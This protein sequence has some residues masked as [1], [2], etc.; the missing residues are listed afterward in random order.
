MTGRK[1]IPDGSRENAV[2]RCYRFVNTAIRPPPAPSTESKEIVNPC[3]IADL[4]LEEPRASCDW[5]SP[6]PDRSTMRN[7]P[8]GLGISPC[9]FPT[10]AAAGAGDVRAKLMKGDGSF[11]VYLVVL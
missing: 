4:L 10:L 9:W 11:K 6:E 8:T 1:A 5:N 2:S 7:C 3:Q